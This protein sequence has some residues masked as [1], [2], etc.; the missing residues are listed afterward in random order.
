MGANMFASSKFHNCEA[1]TDA[2]SHK[3]C[4]DAISNVVMSSDSQSVVIRTNAHNINT[5]VLVDEASN[6]VAT[7]IPRQAVDEGGFRGH[8]RSCLLTTSLTI[9][10]PQWATCATFGCTRP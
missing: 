2:T 9:K 10:T 8:D 6:H 1:C 5:A 4:A 7:T 3:A